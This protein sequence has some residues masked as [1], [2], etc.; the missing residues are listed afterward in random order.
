MQRLSMK[1]RIDLCSA[2]KDFA[3]AVLEAPSPITE[4]PIKTFEYDKPV[5]ECHTLP[6]SYL[7]PLGIGKNKWRIF[8][9]SKEFVKGHEFEVRKTLSKPTSCSQG[10]SS[11]QQSE[12]QFRYRRYRS[13]R[14]HYLYN[15]PALIARPAVE[16]GT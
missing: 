13:P 7:Y 14:N 5:L 3:R 4:V 6:V 10:K 1:A 15:L 16:P 8:F 9:D 11:D 2:A 12:E